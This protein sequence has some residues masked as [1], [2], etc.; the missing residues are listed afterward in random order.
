MLI[1]PVAN[2]V[3]GPHRRLRTDLDRVR[4]IAKFP[5]THESRARDAEDRANLFRSIKFVTWLFGHHN[6]RSIEDDAS[7]AS[8]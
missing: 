2:F 3:G 5:P 7:A 8:L 4:E 1:N 6:E